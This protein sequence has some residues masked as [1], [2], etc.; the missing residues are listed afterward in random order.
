MTIRRI[1]PVRLSKEPERMSHRVD[2]RFLPELQ[3]YGASERRVM[4]QLRQLH[5]GLPA[6]HRTET[7]SR[8]G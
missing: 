2:P 5:G 1:L 7:A 4:L 6:L 3:K 8:A